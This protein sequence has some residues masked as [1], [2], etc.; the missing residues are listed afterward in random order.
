[1]LSLKELL[2]PTFFTTICFLTTICFSLEES[3][4]EIF[5]NPRNF[6]PHPYQATGYERRIEANGNRGPVLFPTT[7]TD[8]DDPNGNSGNINADGDNSFSIDSH[9]YV[10]VVRKR[11]YKQ[12]GRFHNQ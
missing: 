8:P 9:P 4:R 12:A 2:W 5:L 11:K 10:G 7:P 1:M 6:N 3:E